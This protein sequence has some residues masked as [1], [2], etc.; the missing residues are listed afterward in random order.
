VRLAA[1][2]DAP[3]AFGS[4]YEREVVLEETNWR[5][6]L[7]GRRQF[8]AELDRSAVGLAGGLVIDPGRAE[9][10]SMWVAPEVRGLGVG[11]QLVE[12]VVDWALELGFGELRLWVR[13]GNDRAEKLYRRLGF[14][15][16]GVT[17]LVR[18]GES[19]IDFEM[20]TKIDRPRS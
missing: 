4:T 12:A 2:L 17:K 1:L 6:R 11:D 3:Y 15:R 13:T 19:L 7:E 18:E 8:V 5:T 20:V 9:L 16:T 10:V 14:D